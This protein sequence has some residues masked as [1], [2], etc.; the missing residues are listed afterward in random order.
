[1]GG[2]ALRQQPDASCCVLWLRFG[3]LFW[4]MFLFLALKFGLLKWKFFLFS[5][6]S[7]LSFFCSMHVYSLAICGLLF[8]GAVIAS[9]EFDASQFNTNLFEVDSNAAADS[10]YWWMSKGSPFK[11]SYDAAAS[12]PQNQQFDFANN[13]FMQ[14]AASA[15]LFSGPGYLPPSQE[16]SNT[17][18]VYQTTPAPPPPPPTRP[19]T[20]PCNGNGRVCVPNYLC[21]NGVVDAS[22]VNGANSQVITTQTLNTEY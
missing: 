13:P 19:P 22:Q 3:V 2:S 18:N 16:P 9:N 6:S 8:A 14:R 7:S 1:M 4:R 15:K 5:L 21:N 20:V 11:R 10:P 12:A 17:N